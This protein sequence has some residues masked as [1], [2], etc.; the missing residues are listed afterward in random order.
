MKSLN[1][2]FVLHNGVEIPCVGFGTWQTPSD[3]IAEQSVLHAL[4]CGYTHID[5]AAVY[6]NEAS[7][8]EA[9][10]Q[11][12]ID[13]SALFVTSKLWNKDRG[14]EQTIAAFEKTLERLQLDYLDLYLIHW[15]A[16]HGTKEEND[17]V[18]LD[19]WRAMEYL[20]ESKKIRAIGVSN[21]L[22]HHL[23]PLM[24]NASI[25]PMV[26]QIEYHPGYLQEETVDY[27]KK[28]NILVE[29]WSPLGSGKV[30]EDAGLQEIATRYNKSVAHL[31]IRFCLQ[32]GTLPL[33]KS[34]TPSRIEDNTRVF[35]F[36]I[37]EED[38]Q[39]IATR[40]QFG[41][42]GLHPDHREF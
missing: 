12:G 38:M 4:K 18:H 16:I 24:A 35:D 33:P 15:P 14:Y 34:V 7:V 41:W 5:T 17:K 30:L 39:T 1:D 9:I 6:R 37:S 22:V 8:G 20:Y 23:E 21:F 32:N 13:R 2:V 26:N 19:T 29:A 31:C 28:H 42:S 11:S 40:E 10:K 27:C 3:E 25:K 36:V